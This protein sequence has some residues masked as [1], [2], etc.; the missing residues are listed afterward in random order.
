MRNTKIFI[1]LV[2]TILSLAA[3]K[4]DYVVVQPTHG[5][6]D[7]MNY[8]IMIMQPDTSM[9][10]MDSNMHIHVRFTE[11]DNKTVHHAKVRVYQTDD[12]S[13]VI[14]D[15]PNDAHVHAMSGQYD[16]H[17]DLILSAANGVVAH[18]NYTI[19]AKVWGHEA[20]T[21]EVIVTRSFHV[22][23]M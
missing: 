2:V 12:P 7:M 19:E 14:Y 16:H 13:N 9:K 4:K 22:H 20:G 1:L 10:M 6:S 11:A 15:M 18:K 3:C 17:D 8:E 5:H 23:Q 21:H